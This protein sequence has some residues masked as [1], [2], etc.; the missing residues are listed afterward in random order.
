MQDNLQVEDREVNHHGNAVKVDIQNIHILWWKGIDVDDNIDESDLV[1]DLK[2]E[3]V[4][5][6]GPE[7]DSGKMVETESVEINKRNVRLFDE[8]FSA[9]EE[10]QVYLYIRIFCDTPP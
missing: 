3:D 6:K 8:V 7:K 1:A 4:N 10:V 2:V 5:K 9:D